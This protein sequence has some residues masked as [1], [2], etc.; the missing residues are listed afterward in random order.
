MNVPYWLVFEYLIKI[1]HNS[2]L[3][4]KTI[5]TFEFS[6]PACFSCSGI[7][8]FPRVKQLVRLL[9]DDLRTSPR[10]FA[11]CFS[12]SSLFSFF[13]FFVRQRPISH[14][15]SRYHSWIP[16]SDKY[17]FMREQGFSIRSLHLTSCFCS[18]S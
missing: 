11:T 13:T 16:L 8:K 10:S 12:L 3:L 15:L 14:D 9:A 7:A 6:C 17:P 1:K 18:S 5:L 4:E 2:A